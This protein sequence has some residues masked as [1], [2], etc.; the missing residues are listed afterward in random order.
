MIY[1]LREFSKL[2]RLQSLGVSTP[3]VVGALTVTGAALHVA[4]FIVLFFIGFLSQVFGFILNDLADLELDKSSDYLSERPLIKGTVSQN[5]AKILLVVC[6]ILGFGTTWFYFKSLSLIAVLFVVTL[7]GSV[8]DLW[9]KR[10]VGSDLL[11]AAATGLLCMYGALAASGSIHSFNAVTW[12]VIAAG[13]LQM[14]YMNIIDGGLKDAD[15]DF[16]AGVKSIAVRLGVRADTTSY[17]LRISLG[18]KALAIKLRS[19]SVLLLL[20]PF[21]LHMPGFHLWQ[22]F[23]L[24]PMIILMYIFVFNMLF[25]EKYDRE[26][27]GNL[28]RL[29]EILRYALVPIMLMGLIGIGWAL[30]LILLP[31][32]WYALSTWFIY[33]RIMGTPKTL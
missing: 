27:I 10:F 13:F 7:S 11:V 32:V 8:Y 15:H 18:F 25:I 5:Q 16:I 23:I 14:L 29:Q 17:A 30:L 28:I 3:P 20:L 6:F 19:A 1:R 33:G 2:I 21:Y 9:G 4:D 24:F 22:L 31:L 12:I 26:K